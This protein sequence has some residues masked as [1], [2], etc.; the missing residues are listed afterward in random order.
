MSE[1]SK[2]TEENKKTIIAFVSG[3]L[4]GGLMAFVFTSL[5]ADKVA[6]ES[7]E[8]ENSEM[9]TEADSSA[10]EAE[11]EEKT[12]VAT[13]VKINVGSADLK[14]SDQA[15]GSSI[16][17]DRVTYP[18]STG[19]I[20]VRDYENGQMTG[21]LGVARWSEGEGLS[22][23]VIPLMRTTVAGRTYAVIFYSDNGDKEFSLAND[24]Q[25]Q[26]AMS[27]FVAK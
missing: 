17:I 9:E 19:W 18:T 15:A 23:A 5:P 1:E 12:A 4:I 13:T 3:L 24:V 21:L 10:L 8:K 14:I 25:I 26:G 11:E 27:T 7:N 22:P 6:E 16:T 2:I 20:G